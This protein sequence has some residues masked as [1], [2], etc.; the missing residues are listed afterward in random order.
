MIKINL[1]IKEAA[2]LGFK[3][4]FISSNNKVDSTIKNINIISVEKIEDV[5]SILFT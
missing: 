4:I 2:K 1:R 5:V 3:S